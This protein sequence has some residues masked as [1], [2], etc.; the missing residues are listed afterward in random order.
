MLI[1]L[2]REE[3]YQAEISDTLKIRV[4]LTVW[5]LKKFKKLKIITSVFKSVSKITKTKREY[6]SVDPKIISDLELLLERD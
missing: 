1:L 6:F 4:S 5:H 2:T 3:M